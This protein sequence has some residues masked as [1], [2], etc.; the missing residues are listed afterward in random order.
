MKDHD[1][2]RDG[3]VRKQLMP[4][5]SAGKRRKRRRRGIESLVVTVTILAGCE[6][7]PH[8]SAPRPESHALTPTPPQPGA[9]LTIDF[10]TDATGAPL[11]RG[12]VLGEQ[13]AAWGVHFQSSYVVGDRAF[14][15][16]DYVAADSGNRVCTPEGSVMPQF[17]VTWTPGRC[18]GSPASG[19]PLV[20]GFDFPVCVAS[21]QGTTIAE[22]D[23]GLGQM[24][25][26]GKNGDGATIASKSSS[27]F[28]NMIRCVGCPPLIEEGTAG[29]AVFLPLGTP[30]GNSQTTIKSLVIKE[31]ALGSLDNLTVQRCEA[32]FARCGSPTVCAAQG[33]CNS[34]TALLD[35]D[36][37]SFAADRGPIMISQSKTNDFPLGS[38]AVSL[39][40][41]QGDLVRSCEGT[42]NI[43]DCEPPTLTCPPP[44]TVECDSGSG[45][46]V[47]PGGCTPYTAVPATAVDACGPATVP[48][49][50]TCAVLG[51]TELDQVAFDAP[52]NVGTCSSA[53]TVVDTQPPIVTPAPGPAR[54]LGPVDN[55]LHTVTLADCG[56]QITD[57]CMSDIA[58]R[59]TKITCVTSDEEEG[60]SPDIVILDA[61]AQLLQLRA[62]RDAAGDG[63]V[64]TIHFTATDGARNSTP[65]TCQLTV[66][67]L[68]HLPAVDSGPR[69]RV[70]TSWCGESGGLPCE[71]RAVR[72]S[73]PAEG[74]LAYAING[75][76]QVVGMTIVADSGGGARG[77]VWQ[78]GTTV[79]LGTL[80]GEGGCT[81]TAINDR[82]HV[83]G[84]G[85]TAD[86]RLAPFL[87]ANGVIH[88]LAAIPSGQAFGINDRDQIVGVAYDGADARGFLFD[89]GHVTAIGSPEDHAV[90]FGINN[91]GQVV[92]VFDHDGVG[93]AFVWD[94]GII[95]PL[96][97]T[98]GLAS[99]AYAI[100]EEGQ[101]AGST[102]DGV[103]DNAVMWRHGL[104]VDLGVSR[105]WGTAVNS[106]AVAINNRGEIVGS[107]N[108]PDGHPHAF[109]YYKGDL[110]NLNSTTRMDDFPFNEAHGINNNGQIV[111]AEFADGAPSHAVLW[112]K[113]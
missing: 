55:Q 103:V 49:R 4:T 86:G 92:G 53:L 47:P 85:F 35:V 34:G 57:H 6:P 22:L 99:T 29:A 51:T 48:P 70:C 58:A 96:P 50:T 25:L 44:V 87:W 78:N 54:E 16:P 18:A 94:Q 41:S 76:G 23:N 91:S 77:V 107:T 17:P 111:G 14:D 71:F 104:V 113:P 20:V 36:A 11:P 30:I 3:T 65:G 80:G 90:G 63:R 64:Y 42:V 68:R 82:G 75:R 88:E 83:T 43:L 72:L 24:S 10:D 15:F 19:T 110:T 73:R 108:P 79:D 56:V 93:Q 109:H 66:P 60:Q 61:D 98:Y 81:P 8:D 38:T 7:S 33:Q 95:H 37:G 46:D 39:T 100:N 89:D 106:T 45:P 69:R 74:A 9:I 21:I 12:S 13:F 97:D 40:V 52:G 1:R 67:R 5:A 112:L 84:Y 2:A 32:L 31:T 102:F 62:S 105:L 28:V 26:F 101:I 59:G 27:A